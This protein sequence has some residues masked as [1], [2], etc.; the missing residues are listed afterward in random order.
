[1]GAKSIKII[2]IYIYICINVY[3]AQKNNEY[4]VGRKHGELDISNA[5]CLEIV[6]Q[7]L[8]KS[9]RRS[10]KIAKT[11]AKMKSRMCHTDYP[12]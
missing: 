2:N 9:V 10:W 7:K 5:C 4:D 6:S 3:M 11:R 12:N 1:M 8:K